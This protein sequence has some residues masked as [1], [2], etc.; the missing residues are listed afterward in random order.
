VRL[1]PP[2]IGEWRGGPSHRKVRSN[3]EGVHPIAKFV[4]VPTQDPETVG[5]SCMVFYISSEGVCL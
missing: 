2:L 5:T 4:R 3:G 1:E